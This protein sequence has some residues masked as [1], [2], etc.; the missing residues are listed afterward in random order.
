VVGLIDTSIFVGV[1]SG[2][3]DISKIPDEVAVPTPTIAELELGVLMASDVEARQR[4]LTTLQFANS[5]IPVP[6]DAGVGRAWAGLVAQLRATGQRAPINDTWIAATAI[7]NDMVVV[8][9]DADYDNM[10]GIKVVRI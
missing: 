9:Q 8:T 7:A 1:E 6:I 5:L 2:R 3:L 4:R 10:P